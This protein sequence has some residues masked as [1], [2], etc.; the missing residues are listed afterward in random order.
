MSDSEEAKLVGEL[1]AL[2]LRA[3]RGLKAHCPDIE[4]DFGE[5]SLWPAAGKAGPRG[6]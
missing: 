1:C 4:H 2:P 3:L 6:H 5:G